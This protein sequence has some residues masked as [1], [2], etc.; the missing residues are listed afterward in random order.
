MEDQLDDRLNG[1]E[2][3]I[4]GM[5][6]R[7]P[8]AKDIEQFWRNLKE[9]KDGII[10][11][12]DKDLEEAGVERHIIDHPDYVKAKGI[13]GNAEMFDAAFFGYT[14]VEAEL[15]DP[16][17][18]VFHECVW[19]ALEDA[20]YDPYTY[21]GDIGLYAGSSNQLDWRLRAV[22]S[23]HEISDLTKSIL[24]DKDLLAQLIA[25]KLHLTG[26]AYTVQAACATSLL[27]VHLACQALIGGECDIALAGG[28]SVTTPESQGYMYQEHLNES[29]DGRNRTFD[30]K[31]QGTVFSN[32]AGTVVLKMLE[33]ALEDGDHVYAIIK[34]SAVNNDGHRKTGFTAPSPQGQA[35]VIDAALRAAKVGSETISYVEAHGTATLIGDPIEFEALKMVFDN[36]KNGYCSIGSVKS[37]FGHLDAAAGIAGLIKT[38]LALKNKQLP[39][40][41]HFEEPNPRI[42]FENSPFRVNTSLFPWKAENGPLRAGVSSFGIGGT[43]AHLILEEAPAAKREIETDLNAPYGEKEVED[44][45]GRRQHIQLSARSEYSLRQIMKRLVD[46]LL[47][48]PHIPL[49][50]VAYTLQTGRRDFEYRSY[51]TGRSTAEIVQALLAAEIDVVQSQLPENGR[52]AVIFLLSG[53]TLSFP[54]NRVGTDLYEKEEL[55]RIRM[56]ECFSVMGHLFGARYSSLACFQ[57]SHNGGMA[58]QQ[59]IAETLQFSLA[60]SFAALIMDWGIQPQWII[61][62]RLGELLYATLSGRLSLSEGLLQIKDGSRATDSWKSVSQDAIQFQSVDDVSGLDTLMK[63]EQLLIIDL[64][65]SMLGMERI[66]RVIQEP[67]QIKWLNQS[68]WASG[69]SYDYAM[70]IASECWLHGLELDWNHIRRNNRRMKV[71][72]PGYC[73]ERKRYTLKTTMQTL[74]TDYLGTE[75][76]KRSDLSDWFYTPEWESSRSCICSEPALEQDVWVVFIDEAGY[77][78]QVAIKVKQAGY[79]VVTVR[80]GNSFKQ[81]EEDSYQI[82]PDVY[83]EYESLFDRIQFNGKK[84]QKVVH[85]WSLSDIKPP[86]LDADVVKLANKLGFYSIIHLSNALYSRIE[87]DITIDVVT[88]N[89]MDVMGE[90]PLLPEKASI[91]GPCRVIPQEFPS[92]LC[93]YFDLELIGA[94]AGLARQFDLLVGELA[95]TSKDLVVAYRGQKRWIQSFKPMYSQEPVLER[96]PLKKGGVY[97]ITGGLGRVG[98]ELAR[99]L[100]TE[101]EAKLVLVGNTNI[102]D[103]SERE[104]WLASHAETDSI[105]RKIRKIIALEQAGAEILVCQADVADSVIMQNVIDRTELRFGRLNAVIH[106]AGAR[107]K[108][109][110]IGLLTQ[111]EQQTCEE[112]FTPKIY[113]LLQLA[114]VLKERDVDFCVV[115]SSI[116]AILGGLAH[117]AYTSANL[118]M[119]AYVKELN[120]VSNFPWLSVNWDSWRVF[121]EGQAS[122]LGAEV[123]ELGMSA[124]EGIR[125]FQ[126]V[127]EMK[128]LGQLIVSTSDLQ[129]RINR[130]ITRESGPAL[131]EAKEVSH[132]SE[133]VHKEGHLI[134]SSDSLEEALLLIWQQVFG[135]IDI[136]PED[137]FF[138][139]GGDSL[140]AVTILSIIYKRLKLKISLADFLKAESIR[141]LS[142][143][144]AQLCDTTDERIQPAEIKDSYPLS[145]AQLR[146]FAIEEIRD[147]GTSYNIPFAFLLEGEVDHGRLE[148]ALEALV[149]R[150]EPLRTAFGYQN[151]RPIQKVHASVE[152]KMRYVVWQDDASL[153]KVQQAIGNFV[154]PFDI[155][156]APLFKS[157]LVKLS[158]RQ[159]ILFID[160][161]HLVTDGTSIGIMTKDF[162]SLYQGEELPKLKLQYK[163]YAVWQ[164]QRASQDELRARRDFWLNMYSDGVPVLHIP[165]DYDRD[166]LQSFEGASIDFVINSVNAR[167]LRRMS[168]EADVSV[169]M[170][171]ITI[172]YVLLHKLSAQE[173]IVVGTVASGRSHSDV[174]QMLGVFINMLA[175]RVFPKRN[176]TFAEFLRQV[177]STLISSFENQNYQFDDLVEEVCTSVDSGRNPMFDTIFE[178]QNI[179][180]EDLSIDSI[181]ISKYP[182]EHKISQFDLVLI[183]WEEVGS[184]EIS[185]EAV[186]RTQLFRED[187]IRTI[188]QYYQKIAEQVAANIDIKLDE[189]TLEHKLVTA[190]NNSRAIEFDF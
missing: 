10:T 127:L 169:F 47:A 101:W 72:L 52:N 51:V 135:G 71:S 29:P 63:K 177:K 117:T 75:I 165:T 95:S 147:M 1:L 114:S 76:H 91:L 48:Y 7:F 113:G 41:L 126:R 56:N 87:S 107:G 61:G 104:S 49:P 96:L 25:Y 60:Y 141:K 97:M 53:E 9:G 32:G 93:R 142:Q 12:T 14:P 43:N 179:P 37:N 151:G 64:T 148:S 170:M 86:V 110:S 130:W 38:V 66:R 20:G 74:K 138:E 30:A 69:L 6:C 160:I 105:S 16:Q 144:L 173:D 167:H 162:L 125:I 94:K 44:Y 4:I 171:M 80:E 186:Y 180:I 36:R 81:I 153:Q 108:D 168:M 109:E 89:T 2:V 183:G 157:I 112:Q 164:N 156:K 140:K 158:E 92:I 120:R 134:E 106:A 62:D 33:D 166:S 70:D 99:Y 31:A 88:N 185:F 50:D 154:E 116:S 122:E 150:H 85:L 121:E 115:I 68:Y 129:A 67:E 78:N 133:M 175:V 189:I 181:E 34:G 118:F 146:L 39:P 45:L 17:I 27:A 18:R 174:E 139:L 15:M 103:V 152:F 176:E 131:K 190:Q 54:D 90:E 13:I 82:Q 159:Y 187:S 124:E 111:L 73:F 22:L 128:N 57:P 149:Q 145:A 83:K 182:F 23:E 8:G 35:E 42:D 98:Y 40:T 136:D 79:K 3:A 26:P 161:H 19:N 11:L 132:N 163:D 58:E 77:G 24:S 100:S 84:I 46:Y 155:G 55:F 28:V 188:I 123:N 5:S 137:N 143:S 178:W 65:S 21:A 119:D 102:P 59:G 184:E 172:Y